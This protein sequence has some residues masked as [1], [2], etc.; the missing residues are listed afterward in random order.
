MA[1]MADRRRFYQIAAILSF[2]VCANAFSKAYLVDSGHVGRINAMELVVDERI[3]VT[4]GDDGTVRIFDSVSG[5]LQMSAQVSANPLIYLAV[6]PDLERVAVVESDSVSI[7]F[8]T[9]WDLNENRRVYSLRLEQVPL[10]LAYSPGGS[11]LIYLRPDFESVVFLDADRGT[12]LNR[13]GRRS[14]PLIPGQGI[15]ESFFV[16]ASEL[17]IV[18][19]FKSGFIQ[20]RDISDGS[21]KG[22]RINT[23]RDISDLHFI[24]DNPRRAIGVLDNEIIVIDIVSGRDVTSKRIEGLKGIS[25]DTGSGELLALVENIDGELEYLLFA[26]ESDRLLPRY[27][28]YKPPEAER[29]SVTRFED[30]IVYVV[31]ESGAIYRQTRYNSTP[32]LISTNR[33]ARVHDIL[34]GESTLIATE[35]DIY[36]FAFEARFAANPR[37]LAFR[38]PNPLTEVIESM[39]QEI[40]ERRLFDLVKDPEE[41]ESEEAIDPDSTG[42]IGPDVDNQVESNQ[43]SIRRRTDTPATRDED[44]LTDSDSSDSSVDGLENAPAPLVDVPFVRTTQLRKVDTNLF[45][46]FDQGGTAGIVGYYS[47]VE[48]LIQ[49]FDSISSPPIVDLEVRQ[50]DVLSVNSGGELEIKNLFEEIPLFTHRGVGLRSI[51][52]GSDP[53]ILVAGQRSGVPRST[54]FRINTVTLETVPIPDQNMIT[55]DIA[56]EAASGSLYTASVDSNAAKSRTLV[57]RHFGENLEH[58]ETLFSVEG[59]YF[60]STIAEHL[61]TVFFSVGGRCFLKT[62]GKDRFIELDGLDGIP[63]ESE[64]YKEW[65]YT[66]NRDSSISLIS[67]RD[68]AHMANLYLFD[69][70]EWVALTTDGDLIARSRNEGGYLIAQP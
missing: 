48:G 57:V 32:E 50:Y 46:I 61:G 53:Y 4:A 42:G 24:G 62:S 45:L 11:Y 54:T 36:M 65:I 38:R 44:D 2:V 9:V 43:S 41:E 14:E 20:Y 22:T 39:T 17:T 26:F 35:T 70:A 30:R 25:V 19:Y 66:I 12:E 7:H 1:P 52:F 5:T 69:D 58:A 3:L 59:E 23:L 34:P 40:E 18:S 49:L 51:A 68:G 16:T 55:F 47:P 31:T 10:R 33:L 8:L 27:A 63:I 15:V 67:T 64:I 21:L 37:V 6:H 60:D 13:P 29:T 56:Y 28:L